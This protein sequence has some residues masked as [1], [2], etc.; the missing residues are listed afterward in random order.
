LSTILRAL[1]RVEGEKRVKGEKRV[2]GEKGG[3][4]EMEGLREGLVPPEEP[5]APPARP[6]WRIGLAAILTLLV[7]GVF[8]WWLIPTDEVGEPSTTSP[9][10]IAALP[11]PPSESLPRRARPAPRNPEIA[12]PRPEAPAEQLDARRPSQPLAA[13]PP[14]IAEPPPLPEKVA[15]APPPPPPVEKSASQPIEEPVVQP[16]PPVVKPLP[17]P[18]KAAVAP[19][20]PPVEK[21]AVRPPPPVEKP[22]AV[23]P[24]IQPPPPIA[25]PPA[26]KAPAPARVATVKP[27][28]VTVKR[29]IWHPTPERR[30]ARIEAEG[31]K[32]PLE[33][34]E[35]DAVGTLV[36]LEI[37]PSGVVFLHGAE[38]LHRKVGGGR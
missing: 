37:Q 5:A 1:Q 22:P 28:K 19:P 12:A 26:S 10:V 38:K 2:E 21:P 33:L 32:S 8:L 15:V 35:G 4:G 13:P 14:R 16:P 27:P 18:E 30:V 29:T 3:D 20:P 34:H 7:L 25:R 11:E 31:H 9:P 17:P 24:V 6:R 36:V 23:E